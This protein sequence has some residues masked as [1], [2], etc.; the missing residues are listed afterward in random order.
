MQK[1]EIIE[2]FCRFQ[3]RLTGSSGGEAFDDDVVVEAISLQLATGPFELVFETVFLLDCEFSSFWFSFEEVSLDV[4]CASSIFLN[5]VIQSYE[6][7]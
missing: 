3:K 6:K 2:C 1:K 4:F 5:Q 7:N